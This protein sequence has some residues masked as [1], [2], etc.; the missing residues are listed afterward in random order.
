MSAFRLTYHQS[1]V[2]LEDHYMDR[3]LSTNDSRDL[4]TAML[5]NLIG[6]QLDRFL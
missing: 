1:Q 5:Q 4:A 3:G 2:R 6:A